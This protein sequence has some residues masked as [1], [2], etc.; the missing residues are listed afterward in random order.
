MTSQVYPQSMVEG[1][2]R[3][4]KLSAINIKINTSEGKAKPKS[5]MHISEYSVQTSIMFT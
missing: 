4:S 3:E 1:E 2:G 5:K